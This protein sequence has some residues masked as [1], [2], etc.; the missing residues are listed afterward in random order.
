M[1]K[2]TICVQSAV[3]Y[4]IVVE[5]N[6]LGKIVEPKVFLIGETRINRTGLQDMLEHLGAPEWT[7]D[8]STGVEKIIE[9]Y[10]RLCYMAFGTELNPNI[11]KVREG[12]DKYLAN[13]LKSG[14]GSVL[15]HSTLNFVLTDVS[16]VFT[17]EL[18]RHRVGT[19]ISQES[20]RYVR[21]DNIDWYAPMCIL[22]DSEA[23]QLYTETM[24]HL[25]TLQVKLAEHFGLDEGRVSFDKKKKITSAMRR[26]AP[27]G[28]ATKIGWTANMRTIR[29]VLEMRTNPGAEEEIRAV[30]EQIGFICKE[31]YPNLFQDFNLE[32]VDGYMHFKPEYGKV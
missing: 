13:I 7:T 8:A 21:L 14:H 12:N 30:F 3:T 18:V 31:R 28:L 5:E 25:G 24:E 10:G 27:I 1:N 29:Q 9:V 15:E 17:H 32:P 22:E 11:T 20:L 26:I 23:L 4:S 6:E 2:R 16:R 19:A